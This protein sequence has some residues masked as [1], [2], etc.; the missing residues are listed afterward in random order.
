MSKID[1]LK[2]LIGYLNN[3]LEKEL[4]KSV[5]A[6]GSTAITSMP[7][8]DKGRKLEKLHEEYMQLIST[9]DL[10]AQALPSGGISA[11]VWT[12]T[13]PYSMAVE[14]VTVTTPSSAPSA[15]LAP[16][17]IGIVAD[18]NAVTVTVTFSGG[19]PNLASTFDSR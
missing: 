2:S 15:S 9:T 17:T 11:D 5:E 1:K 7:I 16:E 8:E 13:T 4:E 18:A 3:E 10:E 6:K 12:D 19:T 14:N